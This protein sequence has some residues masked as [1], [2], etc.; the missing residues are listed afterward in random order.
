MDWST[1]ALEVVEL[2]DTAQVIPAADSRYE[3]LRPGIEFE[4]SVVGSR[5]I[6][7]IR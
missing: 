4:A 7:G 1:L 5:G 3:K 2:F 6:H